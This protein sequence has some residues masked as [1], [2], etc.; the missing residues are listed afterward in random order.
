MPTGGTVAAG[1]CCR[2]R[3]CV[4]NPD[5]FRSSTVA[6]GHIAAYIVSL[7]NSVADDDESQPENRIY[8]PGGQRQRSAIARGLRYRPGCMVIADAL[9]W[10]LLRRCFERWLMSY[11]AR[12][13][14]FHMLPMKMGGSPLRGA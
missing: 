3:S 6:V 5:C 13:N 12:C 9:R 10:T 2:R 11:L 7:A 14:S 8:L 1:S 4:G